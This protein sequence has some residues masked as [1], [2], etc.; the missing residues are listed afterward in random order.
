MERQYTRLDS[1]RFA[2]DA[3]LKAIPD[4]EKKR[5]AYVHLYGAGQ[6]AA[7]LT[8]KRG[9]SRQEAELAEIAGMLHDYAK[10]TQGGKED[11]ALRSAHAAEA[12]L[13]ELS[14]FTEEEICRICHA[15]A[16]HSQKDA[17][18]SPLDEAL[19]D[20]DE[21]QHYFRNPV[22]DW[23]FGRNRVQQLLRE[24]GIDA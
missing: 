9:G 14:V 2:L 6:A 23:Y 19:K 4:E 15:I 8:M 21:M 17:V 10:Y 5:C 7:F 24:F 22:E 16:V 1:V 18:G 12:L 13:K 20:A 3:A 11:H